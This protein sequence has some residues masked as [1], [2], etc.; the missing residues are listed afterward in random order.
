[1]LGKWTL[2]C[3]LRGCSF[4][5]AHQV[6][7]PPCM[8]GAARLAMCARLLRARYDRQEVAVELAAGPLGTGI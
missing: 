8:D 2:C 5:R 1:M 7:G 6:C 3:L 4:S